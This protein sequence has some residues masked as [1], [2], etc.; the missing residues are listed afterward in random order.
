[1]AAVQRV[2]ERDGVSWSEAARRM[3]KFASQKMPA[4]WHR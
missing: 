4:G 1:M 3:L 2:A